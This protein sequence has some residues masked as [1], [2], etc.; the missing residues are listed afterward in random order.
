MIIL[1]EYVYFFFKKKKKNLG[2][3]LLITPDLLLLFEIKNKKEKG[4]AKET[5]IGRR[6]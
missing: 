5:K 6:E 4:K 1:R 3:I 2:R